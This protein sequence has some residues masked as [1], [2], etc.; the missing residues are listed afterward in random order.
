MASLTGEFQI[1]LRASQGWQ[2]VWARLATAIRL[3]QSL[4]LDK[5]NKSSSTY[6]REMSRRVWYSLCVLDIQAALDGGFFSGSASIAP[7]GHRPLHVNDSDFSPESNSELSEHQGFTDM[8]FPLMTFTMLRLLRRLTNVYVDD[9]GYP[10]VSQSWAERFSLVQECA[11]EL[12]HNYLVHCDCTIDFQHFTRVVGDGM[13]TT[14]R[15]LARRPVHR[16]LSTCPPPEQGIS[17]LELALDVLEQG[18][19]KYSKP[20]FGLWKWFAW[21]KWYAL[22]VLLAELCQYTSGPLYKRAW[23]VAELALPNYEQSEQPKPLFT[24]ME[25]LKQKAE[26]CRLASN[27][28]EVKTANLKKVNSLPAQAEMLSHTASLATIPESYSWI[29]WDAFLVDAM[30]N[31]NFDLAGQDLY[32]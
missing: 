15:L 7:L 31:D 23:V 14:M 29:S 9:D 10:V 11:Q 20:G 25:R 5:I 30:Y 12:E 22:A 1:G 32:Y 26:R 4:G 21:S 19:R 17:V 13:L 18:Q 16:F 6:T 8:T 27:T 28:I 3:A 2:A 24:A